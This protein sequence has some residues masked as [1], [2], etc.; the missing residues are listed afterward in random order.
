[1]RVDDLTTLELQRF[2][3]AALHAYLDMA[4]GANPG[5][6]RSWIGDGVGARDEPLLP[7]PDNRSLGP[8]VVLRLGPDRA[9]LSSTVLSSNGAVRSNI[10]CELS[11]ATGS[12]RAVRIGHVPVTS[13][14]LD[15]A[16]RW[17]IEPEPP[18]YLLKLLGP[19]PATARA[20]VHWTTA[21][22]VVEE[23]RETWNIRDTASAFGPAPAE[24]EQRAERERAVAYVREVVQSVGR[25]SPGESLER[26]DGRSLG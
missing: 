11:T 26:S 9:H 25:S 24:E 13:T 6:L 20:L 14:E 19:L 2:G 3:R 23:Y 10:A 17:V 15:D 4:R 1:M 8:V 12:L 5:S 21:A 22:A 18:A 7:E 16:T